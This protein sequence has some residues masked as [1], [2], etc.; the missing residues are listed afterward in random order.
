MTILMCLYIVYGCFPATGVV[1][2]TTEINITYNPKIF[3]IQSFK[4][5]LVDPSYKES[6]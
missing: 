3:T 4:K 2:V 1:V 5:I 6:N